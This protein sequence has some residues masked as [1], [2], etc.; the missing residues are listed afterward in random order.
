MRSSSL[1]FR[2]DEVAVRS[3]ATGDALALAHKVAKTK[4]DMKWELV[5]MNED[6]KL[7]SARL[8]PLD[9]EG[10]VE[11]AQVVVRFDSNQVSPSHFRF[12]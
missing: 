1:A 10:K 2:G 7:I 3:L 8:T 4:K 6:P 11:L 12:R 9:A 5:K